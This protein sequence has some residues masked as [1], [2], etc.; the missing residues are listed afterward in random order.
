MDAIGDLILS[1]AVTLL[2]FLTAVYTV[3][4]HLFMGIGFKHLLLHWLLAIAGAIIGSTL[5]VRANSQLP[6][7]GEAHIVEASL[8]A[9]ALLV[10][11]GWRARG[12]PEPDSPPAR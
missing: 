4:V 9:L 6:M 5:A 2:F 12:G 11:A 1:P 7:I 10:L 3:A 8:G